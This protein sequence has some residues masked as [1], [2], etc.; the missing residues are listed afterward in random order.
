[1]KANLLV[2]ILSLLSCQRSH[3]IEF[4]KIQKNLSKNF[5]YSV[6]GSE[7]HSVKNCK[8]YI[9]D[10]KGKAN[11]NLRI[12][13]Y[14]KAFIT[15]LNDLPSVLNEEGFDR[16]KEEHINNLRTRGIKEHCLQVNDFECVKYHFRDP[17][18]EDFL[19][20]TQKLDDQYSFVLRQGEVITNKVQMELCPN[21]EIE[22]SYFL[23]VP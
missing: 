21:K 6:V 13:S 15:N 20:I 17:T 14:D 1:M 23:Q 3:Q 4:K 12:A 11:S 2:L 22:I 5:S 18:E 16:I 19:S 8:K 10:I 7:V 9:F